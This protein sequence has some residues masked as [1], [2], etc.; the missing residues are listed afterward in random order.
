MAFDDTDHFLTVIFK[1]PAMF[2]QCLFLFL[3]R[4]RVRK[5]IETDEKIFC[6]LFW[7][8]RQ[9]IE[10]TRSRAFVVASRVCAL[11]GM[12]MRT[13]WQKDM[14]RFGEGRRFPNFSNIGK[15]IYSQKDPRD[16]GRSGGNLLWWRLILVF[17][18][19]VKDSF[20]CFACPP[21]EWYRAGR[22]L[23][24]YIECHDYLH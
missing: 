20:A 6:E 15:F 13:H 17:I 22:S 4:S 9:V 19:F 1:T 24:C 7:K 18:E 10:E 3:W 11:L 16:C 21:L 8:V 2:P 23:V 5:V 12:P 14:S